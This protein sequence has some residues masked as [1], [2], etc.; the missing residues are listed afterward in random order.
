LGIPIPVNCNT[1]QTVVQTLQAQPQNDIDDPHS[2]NTGKTISQDVLQSQSQ[3]QSQQEDLDIVPAVNPIINIF[4]SKRQ[5]IHDSHLRYH[6]LSAPWIA[7][8]AVEEDLKP[9]TKVKCLEVTSSKHFHLKK[10]DIYEVYCGRYLTLSGNS[11]GS[12]SLTKDVGYLSIG[13]GQLCR[14]APTQNYCNKTHEFVTL[15]GFSRP[16]H[17]MKTNIQL[18]HTKKAQDCTFERH[19]IIVQSTDDNIIISSAYLV[20]HIFLKWWT[21]HKDL[22]LETYLGCRSTVGGLSLDCWWTVTQC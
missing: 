2:S 16:L 21:I 1:G 14:D 6:Q 4:L 3:S 19:A 20:R 10:D 11:M 7:E 22:F 12:T 13:N 17:M 8:L 9:G 5:V 15:E 18:Y